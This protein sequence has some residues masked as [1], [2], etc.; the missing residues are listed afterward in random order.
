MKK[1]LV[2]MF[3]MFSVP[4]SVMAEE[5][6]VKNQIDFANAQWNKAF[7]AG[8]VDSLKQLYKNDATLSPG[9][10]AILKGKDAIAQLFQSFVDNGVTNHQIETDAIYSTDD[11]I[12]QIGYWHADGKNSDGEKISF[13]GVL[14]L[15]LVKTEDGSWLIQSHIW[16]MQP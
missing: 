9:N 5:L 14:S 1:F 10:G 2:F 11:Q 16:N 3:S 15:V 12:T 4:F 13:G 6:S 7:N 8:D